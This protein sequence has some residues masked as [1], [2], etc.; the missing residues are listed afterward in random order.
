MI[1]K[2]P[3]KK[4]HIVLIIMLLS[5]S[6][7]GCVDNNTISQIP[8]DEV[9][10]NISSHESLLNNSSIES[11]ISL[12]NESQA[13]IPPHYEKSGICTYVVDGD[14]LD[15]KGVGRI[16]LVGVNTPERG[17]TGYQEAKDFVKS[18]CLGKLIYLD[19]DDKKNNDRYGRV[20]AVVYVG[21]T[22]INAELL[23]KGY[24]EVMYIPPSEFN[25]YSWT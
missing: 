24:A 7:A 1:P 16:R 17:E 5:I 15:V 25:P 14:T 21:N 22:N 20:L 10:L 3:L 8:L 12:T 9:D 4:Y 19:I 6:I 23:K 13:Q 2:N 18:K 11:E